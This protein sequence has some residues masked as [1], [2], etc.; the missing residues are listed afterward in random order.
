MTDIET[1]SDAQ[2][3]EPPAGGSDA[4]MY[5]HV[6]MGRALSAVRNIGRTLLVGGAAVFILLFIV[7]PEI[8]PLGGAPAQ[9]RPL[10]LLVPVGAVFV[11][12]LSIQHSALAGASGQVGTPTRPTTTDLGVLAGVLAG[13]LVVVGAV[14]LVALTT[15]VEVAAPGSAPVVLVR[16]VVL[17]AYFAA[18][19]LPGAIARYV[20]WRDS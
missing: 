6:E 16:N 1:G 9:T 18:Q 15:A 3:D 20:D 14:L 11:Q 4:R 19:L 17:G 13:V 7:P 8:R 2:A 12:L 10:V 5:R